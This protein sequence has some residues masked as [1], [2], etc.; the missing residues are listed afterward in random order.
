KSLTMVLRL[1]GHEVRLARDGPTALQIAREE[2][3]DV[4][5]LDIGM[6][7]MDGYEVARRLREQPALKKP[8]LIAV[9]GYGRQEDQRRSRK[10][11]VNLHLVKPV[12]T[13]GLRRLL[14]TLPEDDRPAGTAA[15]LGSS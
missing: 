8:F 14:A 12:D 7:G 1:W 2:R 6:P 13:E 3:P 11:G 10:A 4:V 5:L 15:D 9:T